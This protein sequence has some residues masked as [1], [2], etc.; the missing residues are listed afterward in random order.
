[1]LGI[2]LRAMFVGVISTLVIRTKRM[3]R[4]LEETEEKEEQRYYGLFR[5]ED[6][7]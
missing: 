7:E 2:L 1:M 6:D 4:H 5:F 3:L